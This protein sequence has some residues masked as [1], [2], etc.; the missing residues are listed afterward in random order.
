MPEPARAGDIENPKFKI[1]AFGDSGSGKTWMASGCSN[2]AVLLLEP[3]G[4]KSIQNSNPD[5]IVYQGS[6][7]EHVRNF[8]RLA[9]T[10]TLASQGIT[11]LLIDGLTEIQR[12]M[13]DEII[14][15]KGGS[16]KTFTL[17]DWGTLGER[18]RM[19]MRTIRTVDY[20]VITTAL[21]ESRVEEATG[22]RRVVP[23][24]EGKKLFNEVAQYF[25]A[26]AYIYRRPGPTGDDGTETYERV[27]MFEGPEKYICKPC[28]PLVGSTSGPAQ[29]W[30]D[31]L[32][33]E[34]K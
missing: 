27:A 11:T 13:K 21:A 14:S 1:L 7:I 2:V 5:A 15:R 26:V 22:V 10:G 24:F 30:F 31:T 9:I 25:N 6:H 3:N 12:L 19:L 33:G 8:L 17:Q 32:N 29:G 4:L 16:D 18:M 34:P 23:Q 20:N 28:F